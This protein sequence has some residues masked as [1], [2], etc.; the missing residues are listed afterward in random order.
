NV[1]A[2]RLV[3]NL[4]FYGVSQ[5]TGSWGTNPYLSFA[6][7]AFVEVLAYVVLNLVLH[8]IGR[9]IPYCIAVTLFAIIALCIIPMNKLMTKDS[10]T[11]GSYAIIYIY[12]NELFPTGVRN[13]GMGICSMIAR[14]GAILGTTCNDLLARVWSD[15]PIVVYGIVSLVAAF[16]AFS[17][18]ETLNKPLPQ[19]VEDVERMSK[20]FVHGKNGRNEE[21]NRNVEG[22][23]LDTLLTNRLK[24]N[25]D[26]NDEQL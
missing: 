23:A 2:C 21:K 6:L 1:L 24:L 18:P 10:Q 12:S 14:V 13:S 16:L 26:V 25:N 20:T 5:N 11:A 22:E 7:S 19:T 3:Q 8:R 15:F 9:K 17:L 4:V